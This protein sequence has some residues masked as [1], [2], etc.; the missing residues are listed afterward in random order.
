MVQADSG[1]IGGNQS[2]EFHILAD[3]GEDQLLVCEQSNYAAN[4]EVCPALDARP[5]VSTVELLPKEEFA[6]PGLHTIDE[7]SK[8]LKIPPHHLVKT[9][10]FAASDEPTV[11]LNPVAVLLRGSDEVNPVKLK[12]H[13]GL[14]QSASFAE[15]RGSAQDHRRGF[16]RK[17]RSGGFKYPHLSG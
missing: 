5:Y 11:K 14:K 17:L 8:A 12:N 10:F 2:Q 3:S 9:M 7:L 16:A 15:R 1:N 13:F 6:T 4:I